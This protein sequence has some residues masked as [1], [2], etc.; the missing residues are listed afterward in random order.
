MSAKDIAIDAPR[1]QICMWKLSLAHWP[2]YLCEAG[3]VVILASLQEL[4]V[5]VA[6]RE[7]VE[8]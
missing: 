4:V 5:E 2:E 7:R 3:L 1:P 8:G 6:K